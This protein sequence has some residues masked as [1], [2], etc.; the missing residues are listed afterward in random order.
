MGS[1]CPPGQGNSSSSAKQGSR[2]GQG[3]G[4]EQESQK[5]SAR[6]GEGSSLPCALAQ[7]SLEEVE[8]RKSLKM[9]KTIKN[10]EETLI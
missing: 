9:R 6:R 7:P 1:P 5:G 3:E 10:E 2:K 8:M 4:W